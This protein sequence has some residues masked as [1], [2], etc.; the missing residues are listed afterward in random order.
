MRARG[1]CEEMAAISEFDRIA[2][3][4]EGK[5]GKP[6]VGDAARFQRQNGRATTLRNGEDRPPD[7]THGTPTCDNVANFERLNA[8][9]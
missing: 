4:H 5:G 3:P 6:G 9:C 7:S 8:M 1:R 2:S